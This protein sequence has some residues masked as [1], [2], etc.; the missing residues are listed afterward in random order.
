[1]CICSCSVYS[2]PSQALQPTRLLCPWDFPGQ[3]TGVGSQPFLSPGDLPSPGVGPTYLSSPALAGEFF[4]TSATGACAKSLQSCPTLCDSMDCSPPGSSVHGDS[5]GKNTGVGCH[6][7]L[8]E[9]FPTQESNLGLPHCRQILYHLSHLGSLHLGI[10]LHRSLQ[11]LTE[12][13]VNKK[14][15]GPDGA[16]CAPPPPLQQNKTY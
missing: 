3:N 7:L 9:I 12:K 10:G 1:M 6:A 11:P 16:I 2:L 15:Q 14:L 5:P 4:T 13:T 8:H